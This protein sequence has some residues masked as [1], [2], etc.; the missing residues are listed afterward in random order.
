MADNNKEKVFLWKSPL[1]DEYM[2]NA[3]R[4]T[5]PHAP[6]KV[7]SGGNTHEIYPTMVTA[8]QR[9]RV[10]PMQGSQNIVPTA[11]TRSFPAAQEAIDYND[12]IG[13][14][15]ADIV[16]DAT[17]SSMVTKASGKVILFFSSPGCG[18]CAHLRSG[19][20][21]GLYRKYRS[22]M[23]FYEFRCTPTSKTDKNYNITGH[24]TLIFFE[25]GIKKGELLGASAQAFYEQYIR[26]IWPELVNM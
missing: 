21:Q 23:T 5:N 17:F 15:E 14:F 16:K 13:V 8:P 9:R 22:A 20:W 7:S 1:Y 26:S 24:P 2:R 18:S 3:G 11:V 6:K 25:G 4:S 12:D 10:V 19:P